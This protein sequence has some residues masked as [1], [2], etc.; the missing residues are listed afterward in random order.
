MSSRTTGLVF[1]MAPL[2]WSQGSCL[3]EGSAGNGGPPSRA[4]RRDGETHFV[5]RSQESEG[6]DELG[7]WRFLATPDCAGLVPPGASGTCVLT[8]EHIGCWFHRDLI[9]GAGLEKG[10]CFG[11]MAG[12]ISSYWTG[13]AV[14]AFTA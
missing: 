14:A 8:C 3:P 6:P 2:A 4:P 1:D 13:P 11:F 7:P 10:V 9:V 5:L 12:F